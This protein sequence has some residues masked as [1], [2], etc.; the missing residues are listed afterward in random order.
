MADSLIFVRTVHRAPAGKEQKGRLRE[1][2]RYLTPRK[3][4]ADLKAPCPRL[5]DLQGSR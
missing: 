1:G 2:V 4:E 3:H 5:N